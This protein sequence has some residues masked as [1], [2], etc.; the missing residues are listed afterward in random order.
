MLEAG[1]S[2]ARAKGV[3]GFGVLLGNKPEKGGSE[4]A[5]GRA[6]S[7][8]GGG[9]GSKVTAD[10][11]REDWRDERGDIRVDVEAL[12]VEHGGGELH[13]LGKDKDVLEVVGHFFGDVLYKVRD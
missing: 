7:K 11:A 3:A 13:H 6:D 5:E 2:E 12:V 8:V 1:A 4:L 9:G 10:E